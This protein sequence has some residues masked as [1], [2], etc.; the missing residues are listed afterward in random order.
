MRG[1]IR[2]KPVEAIA[3]AAY[4]GQ[5]AG[6]RCASAIA[7]SSKRTKEI[8]MKARFHTLAVPLTVFAIALGGDVA[9]AQG[10]ET[11]VV[12]NTAG[13]SPMLAQKIEQ[14]GKQGSAAVRQFISRTKPI[15]Q[16][17]FNDVVLRN[18]ETSVAVSEEP[19]KVSM[20]Q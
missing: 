13:L 9:L 3:R 2:R 6:R 10:T 19:A 4:R 16:L 11:A 1:R 18:A 7:P 17:D 12:V 15:Y 8:A 5:Q 20:N 14:K